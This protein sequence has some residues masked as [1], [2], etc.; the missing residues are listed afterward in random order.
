MSFVP[1]ILCGILFRNLTHTHVYLSLLNG[2]LK[3][4]EMSTEGIKTK[5]IHVFRK[6]GNLEVGL[7]WLYERLSFLAP[8][9]GAC[10]A[11]IHCI[12]VFPAVLPHPC[13]LGRQLSHHGLGQASTSVLTYR[14]WDS[15]ALGEGEPQDYSGS[16]L[17]EIGFCMLAWELDY[18][19]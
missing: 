16:D 7:T 2:K 1:N 17:G 12:G 4:I 5:N 13:L 3:H 18:H 11:P 14:P 8:G 6:P 9:P 15:E 10:P 19:F